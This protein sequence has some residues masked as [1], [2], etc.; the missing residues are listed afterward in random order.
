MIILLN[1]KTIS[2]IQSKFI[3]ILTPNYKFKLNMKPFY[4]FDCFAYHERFK[5]RIKCKYPQGTFPN[6]VDQLKAI[7]ALKYLKNSI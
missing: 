3:L 4:I 5:L 6:H 1:Q 7:H 2:K